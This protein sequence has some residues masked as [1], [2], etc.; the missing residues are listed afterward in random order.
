SVYNLISYRVVSLNGV[1]FVHFPDLTSRVVDPVPRTDYSL[2]LGPCTP[3]KDLSLIQHRNGLT[4]TVFETPQ[5]QTT[6]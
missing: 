5:P 2:F 4:P 6:F 3:V 1:L